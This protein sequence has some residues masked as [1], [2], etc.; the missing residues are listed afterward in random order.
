MTTDTIVLYNNGIAVATATDKTGDIGMNSINLLIGF[1]KTD[2]NAYFNGTLDEVAIWNRSLTGTEINTSMLSRPSA[3]S[4]TNDLVG[5]WKFDE[6]RGI[7]TC[8]DFSQV[9]VSTNC[10]GISAAFDRAPRCS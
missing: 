9:V 4:N 8:S 1:S 10:G 7:L 2:T 6:G 3:V 5:Y